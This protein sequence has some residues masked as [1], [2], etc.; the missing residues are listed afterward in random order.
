M[1]RA[2]RRERSRSY[3]EKAGR[4]VEKPNFLTI[5]LGYAA[6]GWWVF[7]CHTILDTTVEGQPR[8][9]CSCRRLD[10]GSPGKHPLTKNGFLDGTGDPAQIARW[11][12]PER[13]YQPNIGIDCQRSD[14]VVVDID[15]RHGGDASWRRL[16]ETYGPQ[17]EAGPQ[18]L[19]G[20]GG[21]HYYFRNP[22]NVVVHSG[23]NLLGRGID[24]RA[25][26][27]YVI[28]P[29]SCHISGG[30]YRWVVHAL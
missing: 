25:A 4:V 2:A 5:A 12:A 21:A 9:G 3:L 19:T 16:V 20:G 23:A 14:L 11:F 10:C 8:K 28:A 30:E 26:G 18:V 15:P 13:S 29:P 1:R 24:I 7:P 22:P 6:R 27:R 17:L